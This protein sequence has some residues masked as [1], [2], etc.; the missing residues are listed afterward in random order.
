[1]WKLFGI[2]SGVLFSL[3]AMATELV[4]ETW[5]VDDAAIWKEK[6]LPRFHERY[7]DITVRLDPVSS[8]TYDQEVVNRLKAGK[9][10]DLI[11]CR[12]YDQSLLLFKSGYLQ[13]LTELPGMVNFPPARP[14]P[15]GP[16][17]ATCSDSVAHRQRGT[18]VRPACCVSYPGLLLQRRYF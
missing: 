5:R 18:A 1:M 12:P 17:S 11:T 2:L 8:A 10:G 13:D 3:S 6:I 15:H 14:P 7:P 9:A 16:D 4:I